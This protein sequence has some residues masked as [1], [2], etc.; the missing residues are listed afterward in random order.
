LKRFCLFLCLLLIGSTAS[1]QSVLIGKRL[2]SK[3]DDV[4]RVLDIAGPADKVDKIPADE[5][6]PPMEIWTYNR[7]GEKVVLWI[8]GAKVV[9]AQEQP[10]AVVPNGSS[11]PDNAAR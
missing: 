10:A 11:R 9:Q 5:F 8:V 6:S 2:I 4:A 3:G 1:A 7:K